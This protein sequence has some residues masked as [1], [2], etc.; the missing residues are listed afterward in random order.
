MPRMVQL[1]SVTRD[2]DIHELHISLY[3]VLPLLVQ[4]FEAAPTSGSLPFT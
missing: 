1:S 2:K 4:V 3:T